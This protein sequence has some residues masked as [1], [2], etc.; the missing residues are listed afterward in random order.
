LVPHQEAPTNICWGD[1]NR[2]V[3]V[4]VPLGW[5]TKG[6]NMLCDANPL[7][8]NEKKDYSLKQ[9]VEFRCPDGSADMYLLMAGLAVAARHGFEMENAL[10][11]AKDRYVNVNIFHAE[12]KAVQD[13]LDHLPASCVES[14]ERLSQQRDIYEKHGV[15]A[16]RLIDGLIAKLKQHNDKDLRSQ[17]KDNPAKIMELV[18]TFFHCG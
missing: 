18:N 9:T 4:R 11:Y 14:A 10:Q 2:S 7:E 15:F 6:N 17:I 16:P 8:K 13:R 1:R 12:H 3:L 5:S